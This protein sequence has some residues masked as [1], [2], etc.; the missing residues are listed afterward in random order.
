[1]RHPVYLLSAV[2]GVLVLASAMMNLLAME[3]R[4]KHPLEGRTFWARFV[5]GIRRRPLLRGTQLTCLAVAL[6]L[7]LSYAIVVFG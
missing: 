2:A 3:D 4:S 7:Y 5:A 6:V 1:V